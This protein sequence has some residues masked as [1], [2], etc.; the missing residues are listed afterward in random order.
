MTI[1][2]QTDLRVD[3]P[4]RDV[5]E[6]LGRLDRVEQVLPAP[7]WHVFAAVWIGQAL[8]LQKVVICDPQLI[9]YGSKAFVIF[10]GGWHLAEAKPP[11]GR[12]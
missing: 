12:V 6:L 1:P 9:S 3:G 2:D 8:K 4:S 5:E 11:G 10:F 7:R